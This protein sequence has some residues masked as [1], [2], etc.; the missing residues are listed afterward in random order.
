MR[1]EHEPDRPGPD[2]LR[3]HIGWTLRR[4][5]EL[6]RLTQTRFAE[7]AGVSQATVARI[8]AGDRAPSVELLERLFATLGCQVRL[9]LEPLGR[10]VDEAIT[11][12]AELPIVERIVESGIP[13][14]AADLDPIP[15][16]F[17]GTAAALLQGA[18]V[19]VDAIEIALA[20]R[21]CDAFVTW[22]EGRWGNRWHRHYQEFGY[23]P[24]D[25]R[26]PGEHRWRIIG[27]VVIQAELADDLPAAIEVR[28]DGRGYR[29]VP[30]PEVEI[31]AAAPAV[32]LL[33][34]HRQL[35]AA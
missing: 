22:L 35:R 33:H 11:A 18:P 1:Y 23:L 32:A 9:R 21:D 26:S 29:V 17:R 13:S 8:E 3:G 27:G 14:L 12:L 34:R 30:L 6:H 2:D 4:Q 28:H 24:L 5:R 20:W 31:D 7:R 15:H 16:V 25:P 10:R 19:P